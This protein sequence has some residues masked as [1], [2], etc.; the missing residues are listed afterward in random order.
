M[1]FSATARSTTA[2]LTAGVTGQDAVVA[3]LSRPE[4]YGLATGPIEHHSTH[5]AHVFLAGT[6]AYKLKRAVKLPYFDYSTVELR[7]EMCEREFAINH[8]I[9]PELYSGICPIVREG[10]DLRFGSPGDSNIVDWV[11]VMR[12]FDQADLLEQKRANGTLGK[13]VVLRLADAIAEFH[14]KA[15]IAPDHGGARGLRAVADENA[16]ILTRQVSA[17]FRRD[18]VERYVASV[19]RQFRDVRALLGRRKREGR[20]RRCHGD[21]HLNNVCVIGGKPV[22]FDALEFSESFSSIDVLYDL[23]FMLMDIDRHGLR[24]E[25]NALL[26][27]YLEHT[28]DYTGLAALPLFM[29]CRA[30]LRAHISALRKETLAEAD[31]LLTSALQYLQP[32]PR[33]LLAI[34]GYSGSGKT[35]LANALAPTLGMAPGAIVL[36]TD[37]IRKHLMGVEETTRLD[38]KGYRPA[39]SKNVYEILSSNC[40]KSVSAGYV[41]I[42]DGVFGTNEERSAIEAVARMHHVPFVG[43]WLTAPAD[44]LKRRVEG[45]RGDASDATAE[46]I[47]RQIETI[48]PPA[49]WHAIGAGSS[50][51]DVRVKLGALDC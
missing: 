18:D 1:C 44:V 32:R 38:E 21:L 36:R 50:L 47:E 8:A 14:R 33:M 22:L 10:C 11:V 25:A 13:D 20:V 24:A 43:V 23:A 12:R 31:K 27:R 37:V 40:A 42:A 26:N 29:S 15:E 30:A 48:V 39:V 35:T 7:R 5:G 3:F 6:H 51:H 4:S 19:D 46:I 41:A 45:R 34:G 2:A 9:S 28:N 16:E 49:N 17:P